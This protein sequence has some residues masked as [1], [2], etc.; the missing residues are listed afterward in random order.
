MW[1]VRSESASITVVPVLCGA[2]DAESPFVV[3]VGSLRR[4]P[5]RPRPH[6]QHSRSL[7]VSGS[8]AG[9]EAVLE[10]W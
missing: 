5:P 9:D 6:P 4:S 3:G 7:C 8:Q 2:I 10:W 1:E